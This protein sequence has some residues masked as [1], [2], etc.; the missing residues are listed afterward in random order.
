[1]DQAPLDPRLAPNGYRAVFFDA[2]NTLLRPYPSVEEVCADLLRG[3][4]YDPDP[5]AIGRGTILAERLYEE[6][7]WADDSF[8]A[9]EKEA[10]SLWLS[11]Y[12]VLMR[13][14]G[15]EDAPHLG[16]QLYEEFGAGDRWATFPDALPALAELHAA[17]FILGIISNWD[18]R[19]P[20]ICHDLGVSRYLDFI[21]SSA[22]VGRVKPEPSIFEMALAR[23]GVPAQACLHVGDHFY[24]DVLGARSVGIT[25]VLIDR[26][27]LAPTGDCLVVND[28]SELPAH[29]SRSAVAQL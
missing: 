16:E 2:G 3:H 15:I 18:A 14:V 13:E 6:R 4:G 29:L 22:T 28:L 23:A 5:A 20:E 8:W 17:G 12:E 27:G 11:M 10:R 21:I 1:M 7:Y 25:P 24:A 19:L 26:Q 9:S